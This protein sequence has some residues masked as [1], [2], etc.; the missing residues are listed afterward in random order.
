MK[1]DS[2][3]SF[4]VPAGITAQL[5]II[6]VFFTY[7]TQAASIQIYEESFETDGFNVRYTV[8]NPSDDGGNDFFAR[9][10]VFSP[11]TRVSGGTLDGDFFWGARD[12]DGDGIPVGDLTADEARI[13]FIPPI[14]IDGI[15]GLRL[16]IA[17]ASGAD[18]I[19]PNNILL[20][21]ARLDDGPFEALGGFAGTATN[22]AALLFTGVRDNVPDLSSPAL[23]STFHNFTFDI[24]GQG[25]TLELRI[26]V[27]LNGGGEEYAFD[28]LRIVGDD[29]LAFLTLRIDNP[30]ISESEGEQAATVTIELSEPA[31]PEGLEIELSSNDDDTTEINIPSSVMIPERETETTF[32]VDA[33]DDNAF[34]GDQALRIF[35]AAA[36]FSTNFINVTVENIQL[37]PDIIINEVLMPL[38]DLSPKTW[39]A[40]P[41][42]TVS[43]VKEMMNLLKS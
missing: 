24:F 25:S 39:T 15:G 33:V 1:K 4:I 43:G 34:D 41:I 22:T 17:L 35:A 26:N 12:I 40:M 19:E 29:D 7:A 21:E 32:G 14:D 27:R 3:H 13:T 16:E 36:G 23:N 11:G 10:E 38:L 20:I 6:C 37:V 18:S 9:R 8:E 42:T 5:F 31:P 28:N 2:Y 30:V